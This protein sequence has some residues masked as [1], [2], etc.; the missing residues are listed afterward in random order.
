LN[1]VKTIDLND[2][3]GR[4]SGAIGFQLCQWREKDDR[5]LLQECLYQAAY[6][7]LNFYS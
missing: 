3:N 4:L 2:E 6:N 7:S 1:G 5:C